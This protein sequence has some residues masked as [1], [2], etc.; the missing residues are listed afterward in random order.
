MQT[1]VTKQKLYKE[2]VVGEVDHTTYITEDGKEFTS[3]S[4][5]NE[6]ENE[7]RIQKAW[8]AIEVKGFDFLTRRITGYRAKDADELDMIKDHIGWNGGRFDLYINDLYISFSGSYHKEKKNEKPT[9]LV[10][11]WIFCFIE[12]GGDS[13]DTVNIFTESY[14]NEHIASFIKAFWPEGEKGNV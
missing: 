7:L 12:D 10:G 11:E 6:H 8:N 2:F 13:R 1:I 4:K 3:L 9:A 5:A 14:V